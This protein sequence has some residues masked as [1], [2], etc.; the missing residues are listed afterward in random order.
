MV[1]IAYKP[2]CSQQ[3]LG[4]AIAAGLAGMEGAIP[5]HYELGPE[6]LCETLNAWR[7]RYGA[8]A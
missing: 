1:G 7:G 3:R 4:R 6:D 2:S 8:A 5:D